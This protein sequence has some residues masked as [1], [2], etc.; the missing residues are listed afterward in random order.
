MSTGLVDL[1]LAVHH[2]TKLAALV[3]ETGDEAK[4]VWLPLSKIELHDLDKMVTG[5]DKRGQSGSLPL[6]EVTIPEW[7]AI[8]KGLV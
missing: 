6:F 7:L 8:D 1:T 3:S 5:F 2:K 4:A